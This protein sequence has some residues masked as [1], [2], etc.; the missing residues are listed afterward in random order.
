M[1]T[2]VASPLRAAAI[3]PASVHDLAVGSNAMM[4]KHTLGGER[5]EHRLGGTVSSLRIDLTRPPQSP[6]R[7]RID[8]V[9][10][11]TLGSRF[12]ALVS[13]LHRPKP[14]RRILIR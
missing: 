12:D 7:P 13:G 8:H 4:S 3:D 9:D 10:V 11:I 14:R 6:R 1:A 2:S 5:F